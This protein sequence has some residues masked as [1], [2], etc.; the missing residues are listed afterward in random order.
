GWLLKEPR[1]WW[2]RG[3]RGS[4]ANFSE[5]RD[6]DFYPFETDMDRPDRYW[7]HSFLRRPA[8]HGRAHSLSTKA[9][10]LARLEGNPDR[11]NRNRGP[12]KRDSSLDTPCG[13]I[14]CY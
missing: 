12:R 9:R 2:D 6:R 3:L 5:F 10:P 8:W 13:C 11:R 4:P 1:N 7:R 14:E